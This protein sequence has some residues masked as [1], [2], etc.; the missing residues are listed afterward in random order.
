MSTA[1]RLLSGIQ[2]A[3]SDSVDVR[4]HLGQPPRV[5]DRRPPV[6][7]VFP[8]LTFGDVRVEDRSGD[9]VRVEECTVNL[10]LYSRYQGRAEAMSILS[11]VLEA[12]SRD[13]LRSFLP[14]CGRVV[15]RFTDSFAARDGHSRHSVLRITVTLASDVMETAA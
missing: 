14:D 1:N 6:D 15:S 12:L 9:G 2:S 8:F 7:A 11:G 10:H 4:T 5:F 13:R 3:L